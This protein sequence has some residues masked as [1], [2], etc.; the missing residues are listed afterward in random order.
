MLG[1]N[2]MKIYKYICTR[3][4]EF[5]SIKESD[6]FILKECNCGGEY[7]KEEIDLEDLIEAEIQKEISNY[8]TKW[9]KEEG[10]EYTVQLI[11][12]CTMPKIKEYY[13]KELKKRG[14]K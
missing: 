7:I 14:L 13:I 5:F 8:V 6:I 1:K 10:I 2:K 12:N 11:E 3:C 9:L 4:N